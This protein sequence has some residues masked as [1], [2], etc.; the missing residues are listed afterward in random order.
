[1]SQ[2]QQQSTTQD[3][4]RADDER[5]AQYEEL[6]KRNPVKAAH[7]RVANWA[8]IQSAIE[9]RNTTKES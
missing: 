1:M 2:E 7:F 8:S 9:R 5:L 6:E 4:A 3:E